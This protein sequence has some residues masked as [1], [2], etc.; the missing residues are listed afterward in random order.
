MHGDEHKSTT[1]K[2]PAGA[3]Y[4]RI[5]VAFL[6]VVGYSALMGDDEVATYDKW[7]RLKN[8]FIQ[9]L[10]GSHQGHFIKSTGDGL[11]ASFDT[12][13]QAL[14][15]ASAVQRQAR[16]QGEGLRMRIS[17]NWGDAI[18][19]EDN[20][21]SG[22][23]VN[24]AARLEHFALPGG[25]IMTR[26]F[27][28][29]VAKQKHL[30]V[31]PAGELRLN[32]IRDK[33][34]AYHLSTDGR[35]FVQDRTRSGASGLP[36]IAILPLRSPNVES[37]L[38]SGIV[39]DLIVS[40]SGM[41]ELNIIARST[42]QAIGAQSD[43]DP[44]DIGEAL[45]VDYLLSGTVQRAG[46]TL[47]VS[48]VLNETET[49]AVVASEQST[50]EEGDLFE[51]QD[52]II[53]KIVANITPEVRSST[54]QRA[55]RKPP[56]NFTAYEHLL[57]GLERVSSLDREDFERAKSD[58]DLAIGED[59][60]FAMP[61]AWSARWHTLRV[62]QGWSP[63]PESDKAAARRLA[64]KAIQ[65]DRRNALALATFGHVC[66][67][68]EGDYET[69]I[70]YL[71]RA[72]NAGPNNAIAR[73]LRSGTLSFLGRPAEAIDEAGIALR[74]SP[75]DE[76]LFQFYGFMALAH[77][78]ADEFAAAIRWAHRS[79]AEN[80]N[81]THTLKVLIAAETASEQ[82]D[83]AAGHAKELMALEPN[84]RLENYLSRRAPFHEP[85]RV[86]T[87]IERLSSAGVPISSE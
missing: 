43:V 30:V 45:A 49:G 39:D 61:Y 37:Y 18:V 73:T 11:L 21:I 84:F 79:L 9:P 38:C 41:Q 74:L 14:N 40:L 70:S 85:A 68:L 67:F 31:R 15:W 60:N 27:H 35:D 20:D 16:E 2:V 65:L 24:I 66:A 25:V 5:A 58:L 12:S 3:H 77:Y 62:G 57:R 81:Y 76:Q 75:F 78:V 4:E 80:P 33:V 87:L 26:Q 55:L 34:T 56:E 52:Q 32:N 7:N 13:S 36:S 29:A 46:K 42:V 69:A 71:D 51:F 22:D 47:R 64:Q 48:L 6:D 86:K 8:G 23:S 28:D 82:H 44:R 54:L 1:P 50:F 17:L 59:G 10:L 83:S 63:D 72:V 19:D 53:S